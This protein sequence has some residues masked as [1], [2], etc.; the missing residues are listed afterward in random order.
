MV[1][2][3]AQIAC[4]I[5]LLL[6]V[7]MRVL[8][9]R[10]QCI[11]S[12]IDYFPKGSTWLKARSSVSIKL[13]QFNPPRHRHVLDNNLTSSFPL[14]SFPSLYQ[15]LYSNQIK[16]INHNGLSMYVSV[17]PHLMLWRAINTAVAKW[18]LLMII[19]PQTYPYHSWRESWSPI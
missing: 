15:P 17:P 16:Q 2:M 12:K 10:K 6:G 9:S 1:S 11:H 18:I 13:P 14:I 7:S 8:E 19:S 3:H 5:C 4:I